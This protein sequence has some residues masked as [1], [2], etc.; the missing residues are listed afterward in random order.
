MT[1][2]KNGFY[3]EGAYF[4]SKLSP[5]IVYTVVR[6]KI[7]SSEKKYSRQK[8][9]TVVQKKNTVVRKKIQSC[10]KKIQSSEKNKIKIKQ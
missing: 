4:S 3:T 9:N 10:R 5:K 6:K 7:Q 1:L 2:Q 8:K